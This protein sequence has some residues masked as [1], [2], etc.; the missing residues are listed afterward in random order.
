MG[1]EKLLGYDL[2]ARNNDRIKCNSTTII[3][4]IENRISE[5]IDHRLVLNNDIKTISCGSFH[6]GTWNYGHLNPILRL[7]KYNP[8]NKFD[9]HYDS[10]YNPNPLNKRTFKTCMVYLNDNYEDGTT[11]FYGINPNK[12]Y[13]NNEST[14]FLKLKAKP[15]MCLIFNQNI[16]H[17]G[18]VVKNG[19]KYM[20]RTDMIYE[21]HE[22]ENKLTKE[23]KEGVKV[24]GEGMKAEQE[25]RLID[26]ALLYEKATDLCHDA[27]LMYY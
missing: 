15:G 26:A 22:L 11:R 8:S 3:G 10:G 16:L 13:S 25:G 9:K 19:N 20:M 17:D 6:Y 2:N 12:P 18:D 5:F 4:E 7:C 27:Y 21:A 24:Y 1:Y 14:I 23:E